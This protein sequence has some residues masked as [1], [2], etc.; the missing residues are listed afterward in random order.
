MD[1]FIIAGKAFCVCEELRQFAEQHPNKKVSE[2]LKQ[3]REE[4]LEEAEARQFGL[5]LDE[6]RKQLH[7]E[8]GG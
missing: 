7:I 4:K 1:G 8:K 5:S 3:R 2:W 6:Y